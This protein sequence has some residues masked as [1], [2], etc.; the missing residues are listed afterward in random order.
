MNKTRF[1]P[2]SRISFSRTPYI[3]RREADDVGLFS[4]FITILGGIDYADRKGY[5][6]VVDMKNYPNAYLYPSELGQV[7][8]WEYYFEQPGNV[9][10]DE[11]L[12]CRKYILGKDSAC[13][14]RPSQSA[15]FF[16]GLDGKLD[17][18]RGLCRKYIRFTP[19]V[20]ERLGELRRKAE[21]RR[22]LGVLVR[23]TDYAALKPKGHPIPPTAEQAI[24][25]TREALQEE[26][27]DAVYLATEDKVILAQFRDAF[28]DKLMLPDADYLDYNYDN[29]K[30]LPYVQASR[31]NDKYLRGLEYLVSMLFLSRCAGFI[32]SPTSGSTGV[33]CLSEG[34]E[35]L[36]VFAL[37]E[38][39]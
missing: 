12:S 38:Y 10:L 17:Y 11:A 13:L 25:K 39:P 32:T 8:A 7:N 18:W 22:V 5:I 37:G 4:Y 1:Q 6:P 30:Y 26:G 23:G 34:F 29:P 33:V 3:I 2:H 19:A 27:F 28:G 24:A 21:S 31:A 36:Y 16:Y 35:Y 14:S 20:L 9:A 15:E